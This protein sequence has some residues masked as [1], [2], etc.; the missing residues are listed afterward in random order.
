MA[1]PGPS[2]NIENDVSALKVIFSSRPKILSGMPE[3]DWEPLHIA[4]ALSHL[5]HGRCSTQWLPEWFVGL[6]K[7]DASTTLRM[8]Q[9]HFMF[10]QRVNE[11]RS[12][13]ITHG[14]ILGCGVKGGT[15]NACLK[16]D[17]IVKKLDD[18]PELPYEKC[19]CTQTGCRCTVVSVSLFKK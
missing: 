6:S 4:S 16:I 12:L 2:R 7:F 9:F 3:S 14:E 17:G 11:M 13:G 8:M 18:L 19:T 15:C 5:L 10:L 1:L